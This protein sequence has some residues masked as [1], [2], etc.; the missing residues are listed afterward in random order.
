[1]HEHQRVTIL[2]TN[3]KGETSDRV[4]SPLEI[5]YGSTEWYPEPQW[6]LHA[7]CFVRGDFRDFAMVNVR[8][9]RPFVSSP[10]ER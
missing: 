5:F 6:L 10:H 2:Y 7:Y 9:W 1:M 8:E 3:H 4:I